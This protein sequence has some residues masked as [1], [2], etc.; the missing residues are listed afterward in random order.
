MV[1]S[2]YFRNF[3]TRNQQTIRIMAN[4]VITIKDI[5]VGM[6]FCQPGLVSP[7]NQMMTITGIKYNKKAGKPIKDI[8][9]ATVWNEPFAFIEAVGS[10]TGKKQDYA[11]QSENS[12]IA[13]WLTFVD[14]PEDRISLIYQKLRDKVIDMVHDNL[15]EIV[16][17]MEEI[18][19]YPAQLEKDDKMKNLIELVAKAMIEVY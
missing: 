17:T 9:G 19:K 14:S 8:Y 12:N 4:R 7:H 13:N 6:T 15:G 1:Y 3:A 10:I 11:V 5:N 2:N 16:K 18:R